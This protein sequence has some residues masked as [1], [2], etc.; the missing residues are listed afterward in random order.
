MNYY[1]INSTDSLNNTGWVFATTAT[2]YFANQSVDRGNNTGWI[3]T[4]VPATTGN[5]L[6]G[7]NFIGIMIEI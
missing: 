5:G 7:R 6:S 1:A 4:N 2:Y 3:F